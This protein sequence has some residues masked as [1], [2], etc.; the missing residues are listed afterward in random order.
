MTV[1]VA[2]LNARILI[3]DD[4]EAN[5]KVLEYMLRGAGYTAVSSTMDSRQVIA[6]QRATR[7][8][9]IVL[10]L[11]MPHV[12]GFELLEALKSIEPDRYASV[13]VVT[14][15]PG[16][17]VRALQAGARDFV[18]K[19]FDHVEVLT[20]IRNLVEVRQLYTLAREYGERM[21]H[22]DDLTGLP[23]RSLL[24]ANLA[25]AI[26]LARQQSYSV[27]LMVV[28]LDHFKKLN[29]TL[30][31]ALGDELLRRCVQRLGAC[32]RVQ[33][34][35][36]RMG[37]DEFACILVNPDEKN[38]AVAVAARMRSALLA[39]F[40]LADQEHNVSASVGIAMYPAHA[41]DAE[42]LIQYAGTAMYRAKQAGR[43]TWCLF[44]TDMNEHALRRLALE[45]ALRKAVD[46][47]EFVLHYQPKV[48]IG[49]CRMVGAEALIRWNRPGFG[50]VAPSEFIP[51]LEESGLIV[52]V[53]AWVIDSVCA[54]LA[55]W[56]ANM[57]E[58]PQ[59]AINVSA[60][61]FADGQLEALL[62]RAI[63]ANGID[64]RLLG[65]EITESSLMD[66]IERSVQTL[67]DLKRRGVRIAIDD[68]GT[69][70]S[71]LA[72]LKKFPIDTLKIDIAFIREVTT[73]PDDAAIARAIIGLGHSLNLD[74]IAEGVETEAQLAF[75]RRNHCDQMQGYLFSHPLPLAEF[76]QLMEA[77]Q[78]LVQV[79]TDES[80]PTLLLVD[81]EAN[82][83]HAL[84]RLLRNDGYR[85]LT[86]SDARQG[87]ELLALHQVQVIVCDQRMPDMS[88]TEFFDR[89]KD[90][91][92]QTLRIVLSGYTDLASISDAIN[93][94]ALYRFFTKPWDND[95]MRE[96]IRI[97]FRDY[98]KLHGRP[99]AQR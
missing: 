87:L 27:A 95:E 53:G 5:V 51:L 22:F 72:Y 48:E 84:V 73:S 80:L 1:P 11:N 43:D 13:L 63:L 68:F 88:G 98:W 10:D 89:V 31:H 34:S 7:F 49:S 70:Y 52:R 26:E 78:T 32:L 39:P 50:L 81:D 86:A 56:S 28:D 35:I 61:Q 8:D 44:T 57:A 3:V 96:H 46:N 42:T 92:P 90:L 91:Y 15:E 55:V 60:R 30:G 24:C 33:D 2:I 82:V 76:E 19:P 77:R 54:Q 16:H 6:M 14:A 65:L 41:Q 18:S 40:Q 59:V 79:D 75:L 66:N 94:G 69:G 97:A 67:R 29:D 4:Q 74:V 37:G 64:P 36:G 45:H 99:E 23:N 58:P 17:K 20:R 83:L 93:R 71:S 25:R 12:N 62:T 38:C 21:A 47:Q 85:I 9:L